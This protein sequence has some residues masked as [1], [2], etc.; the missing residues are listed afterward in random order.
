M[1]PSSERTILTIALEVAARLTAA[2]CARGG[3][4]GSGDPLVATLARAEELLR[5][6]DAQQEA[7]AT[8]HRQRYFPPA[9]R[10]VE[11]VE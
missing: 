1:T 11:S 7:R 4:N 8:R 9:G 10:S 3:S 5:W 2:E 6:Y